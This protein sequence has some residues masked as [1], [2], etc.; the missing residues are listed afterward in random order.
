MNE[1]IIGSHVSFNNKDQLLGSVKE[2]VSYGSNTFMFYTGAPQN[3]RRG[4]I[5]DFVTLEA[6]KLMKENNIELD[7]VIVH[8]PYIVNL[9]NP[10]NM[11]FSID[12]LTNEVERCNLLGMKYLVLHPGSSVNVSREEG[13]ANIIKGLNAILT[14]N[15]NICICLETMA[16]KGNELGRNFLELKEIIDGVNFKD[17]IG[18]CMDTCHLFDSGIDI[19]DFDKVLDDFDKQ[20]GL[21]YL[22]WI[23]IND[24]K[25]IF[26]SHKDRHE[27]I[28]YGN[29]GFDILI[30]IIYNE[31]IKNI[32]KILE[33]P[34]VGKTDDDKERIYPPY[35]YE[36]EMIRNKK[37]DTSLLEKIRNNE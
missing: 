22:K 23:H 31:R 26:S 27:N 11:E 33:T 14:N 34:Y 24:S 9:A 7:K 8:A 12:F 17:S 6:Y 3:T 19:T 30:K 10:D 15:N 25:N 32:P 37:F 36:I 2:A 21:N 20:I 1:L 13:I 18:V 28:G 29:I 35:K 16:G 5:N 4:E